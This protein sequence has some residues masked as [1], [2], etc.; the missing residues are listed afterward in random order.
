MSLPFEKKT[1][2]VMPEQGGRLTPIDPGDP[3]H[4]T[5]EELVRR[6]AYELYERRGKRDGHAFEDWVQA[7]S[8]VEQT[9]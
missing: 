5:R 4:T 3:V 2:P 9:V 7:E 6:K 8:Q 1:D